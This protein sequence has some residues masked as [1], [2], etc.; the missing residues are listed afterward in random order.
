M[1]LRDS[2]PEI[3]QRAAT[4]PER[5]QVGTGGWVLLTFPPADAPR[6][7]DLRRWITESFRL[8]APTKIVAQFD[9]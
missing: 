4:D 5:W 3:E 2:I 7:A 1:P 9:D 8:L 6:I